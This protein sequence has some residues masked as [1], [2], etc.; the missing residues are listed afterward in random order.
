MKLKDPGT[1]IDDKVQRKKFKGTDYLVLKVTYKEGVGDDVWYFYF[2][3][4]TYAMEVYQFY[5]NET[6]NDGEY[7]LLDELEDI[8]G[9]KMPKKRAW[10][11]N[12]DNTYL[13]TDILKSS[14]QK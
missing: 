4:K 14:A 11:Y 13:A 6:K 8:N 9:I 12:Q 5:H 2:D 10:F 3:P 1:L 7:I